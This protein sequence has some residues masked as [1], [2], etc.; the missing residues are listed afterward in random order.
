M[1]N[2]RNQFYSHSGFLIV[3]WYG[4]FLRESSPLGLSRVRGLMGG[5][6]GHYTEELVP[7][8]LLTPHLLVRAGFCLPNGVVLLRFC[9]SQVKNWTSLLTAPVVWIW[10]NEGKVRTVLNTPFSLSFHNGTQPPPRGPLKGS[11]PTGPQWEVQFGMNAYLRW[12]PPSA[13]RFLASLRM[14]WPPKQKALS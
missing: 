11:F 1:L 7:S 13:P 5:D 2:V 8:T 6:S 12:C 4:T 9:P 14:A 3:T 10:W